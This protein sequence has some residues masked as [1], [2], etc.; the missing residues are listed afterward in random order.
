MFE[1]CK[2]TQAKVAV[3]TVP[4]DAPDADG[5]FSWTSTTMVLVSLEAGGEYDIGYTYA[6]AATVKLAAQHD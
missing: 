6:D 2:I 4:S 3:Y 5:T 1:S